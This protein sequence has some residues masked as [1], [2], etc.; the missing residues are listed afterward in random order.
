MG[1]SCLAPTRSRR[2]KPR[3][4]RYSLAGTLTRQSRAGSNAVAFSG[5]IGTKALAAGG[6][7][8]LLQATNVFGDTSTTRQVTF[9]IL[10]G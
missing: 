4:T 7:R 2:S 9:T 3:C 8:A 5:R 1:R 6:Y 10:R